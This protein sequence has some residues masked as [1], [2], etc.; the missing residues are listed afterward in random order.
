M[1]TLFIADLHLTEEEPQITAKFLTFIQT[2]APNADALYIL[3]DLYA[4]W[5]GEDY[6]TKLNQTVVKALKSLSIP[7]YFMYGNRDFLISKRHCKKWGWTFLKDPTVVTLYNVPV[8]LSHGDA[9]CTKD[10]EYQKIRRLTTN[11][12]LQAIVRHF[13]FF[14]RFWMFNRYKGQSQEN[15]N[16]KTAEMMD[17]EQSTI[18]KEMQKYHVQY[19][20]HGHTHQCA[21]HQFKLADKAMTR[22]VVDLWNEQGHALSVSPGKESGTL[23]LEM[24]YF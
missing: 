3:G 9:F 23:T 15:K 17:V 10:I 16:Y 2:M 22:A 18:E 8:L 24:L 13:P 6:E 11:P 7:V 21:I 1:Q 14:V 4:A 20:I 19:L 12:I 5:L